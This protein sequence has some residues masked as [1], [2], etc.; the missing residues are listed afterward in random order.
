MKKLALILA[1]AILLGGGAVS[2]FSGPSHAQGY[3]YPPPPADPYAYP[4]VGPDTPWVYYNGDWFLNG[5][6]Y[7]FFGSLFGWAPYYAYDYSYIVRPYDWY[8]PMWLGWYSGHPF[9][10]QHF[11]QAYPYWAGHHEGQRYDRRFY[12]EHHRGQGGGWQ[13]GFKGVA[14]GGVAHP[15][16]H[17]IWSPQELQHHQQQQQQFQQRRQQ[18][19]QQEQLHMQQPGYQDFRQ[20]QQQ[21][22]QQHQ[23]RAPSAPAPHMAPAPAPHGGGGGGGGGAPHGGGGGA[24][25][26]GGGHPMSH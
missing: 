6:L 9:Y 21:L 25:H 8:G 14:P 17:P 2:A 4:W 3:E 10:W 19:H 20:R 12:D 15:G 16:G 26:G 23:M 22:M 1:L 18:L 5:I 7:Y 13:K 24:P 11:R